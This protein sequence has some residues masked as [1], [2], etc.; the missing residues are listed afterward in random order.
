M[1][2][3]VV[4]CQAKPLNQIWTHQIMATPAINDSVNTIT[5][6]NKIHVDQIVVLDLHLF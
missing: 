2:M 1:D 4:V 3:N 6:H 5:L